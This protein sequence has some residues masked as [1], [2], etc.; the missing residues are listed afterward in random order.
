MRNKQRWLRSLLIGLVMAVV[1]VLL[2][3]LFPNESIQAILEP[4]YFYQNDLYLP[5]IFIVGTMIYSLMTYSYFL[6]DFR[7]PG[8]K[9]M[10]SMQFFLCQAIIWLIYSSEPLPHIVGIEAVITPL[11]LIVIFMV[12]AL[13]IQYFIARERLMYQS[14]P[15]FY[16]RSLAIF[17]LVFGLFRLVSYVGFDI[18][19]LEDSQ[20]MISVTWSL[21][22]GCGIG[23]AFNVLQR[24]LLRQ[25]RVG[26]VKQFT[27][28]FF[29]LNSIGYHLFILLR[30]N[31]DIVDVL[32]R[33]GLDILA[34]GLASYIVI[35]WQVEEG[36]KV[37]HYDDITEQ[38]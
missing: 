12:Q 10:K 33:C 21:V 2:V 27:L 38:K 9:A 14:K 36:S 11:K 1:H 20:L 8:T 30:Y 7:L 24:Y 13:L 5:A 23:L 17:T 26:K 3:I 29:A 25:D 34:V 15:F 37:S 19:A 35:H 28:M 22:M 31:V 16:P 32:T 4:S 18:Y 6:I